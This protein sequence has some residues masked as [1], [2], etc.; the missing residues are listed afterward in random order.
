MRK[1]TI[2]QTDTLRFFSQPSLV[3]ASSRA[4]LARVIFSSGECRC[5]S[6]LLSVVY[7]GYML[8]N[9]E[10]L[11]TKALHKMRAR[12]SIISIIRGMQQ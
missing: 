8:N 3:A 5:T 11:F 9:P 12:S 6:S 1:N 2:F 10:F 4:F 7:G